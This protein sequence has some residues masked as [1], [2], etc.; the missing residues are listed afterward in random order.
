M[1]Y[2]S[3]PKN[4]LKIDRNVKGL[5]RSYKQYTYQVDLNKDGSYKTFSPFN[6]TNESA[7][8][9]SWKLILKNELYDANGTL[10]QSEDILNK[11]ISQH[12]GYNFSNAISVVANASYN[13]S[14]YEGAENTYQD[15]SGE[16]YLEAGKVQLGDATIFQV[17]TKSNATFNY[18]LYNKFLQIPTKVL[19]I[20]KP[21]IPIPG[22]V[23][24]TLKGYLKSGGVRIFTIKA[25]DNDTYMVS[26]DL[27]QSYEGFIQVKQSNSLVDLLVF[28]WDNIQSFTYTSNNSSG[29][30]SQMKFNYTIGVEAC[31]LNLPYQIPGQ[32]PILEAHTGEYVFVLNSGKTG[33]L[34]DLPVQKP[35][36]VRKFKAMVWVANSS[37]KSSSLILQLR[38]QN[39]NVLREI[40]STLETPYVKAGN[41]SMLRVN[42]E[43][44]DAELQ[45]QNCFLRAFV[46]NSSTNGGNTVYDDFRVL[47]YDAE[48]SNKVYDH[49]FNRLTSTLD[50]DNFA[51]YTKYDTRGRAIESSVE[52]QNVGRKVVNKMRYNDQ[53][54]PSND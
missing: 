9:K 18:P 23:I 7:N 51:S 48:M 36:Q 38:D 10:L 4:N 25:K 26:T 17:N 37:P 50:A 40:R 28:D 1:F 54:N 14:A 44:T 33:T 49:I 35:Q 41:W 27:G 43:L 46:K 45:Y 3:E 15:E 6:Y 52:I 42:F 31:N 34:V 5:Y 12:M 20:T 24:G 29:Y 30:Q 8:S 32:T 16:T 39:G 47:P 21:V 13:Q 11:F 22:T 2:Y 53:I 19:E